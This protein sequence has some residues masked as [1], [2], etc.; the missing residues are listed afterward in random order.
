MCKVTWALKRYWKLF[1]NHS[2]YIISG[3]FVAVKTNIFKNAFR[4]CF[5]LQ[6]KQTV[7]SPPNVELQSS[8]LFTQRKC[9]ADKKKLIRNEIIA[10]IPQIS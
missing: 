3:D 10:Q 5:F 9:I 2:A 8:R 1:L 7:H 4:C 6:Q